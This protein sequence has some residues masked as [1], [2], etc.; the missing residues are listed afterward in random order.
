M[1]LPSR[2]IPPQTPLT[3]SKQSFPMQL[4]P[5]LPH[6]MISEVHWD[7]DILYFKGYA[8]AAAKLL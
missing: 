4:G 8:A 6:H 2:E 7:T 5:L 3:Q 1:R